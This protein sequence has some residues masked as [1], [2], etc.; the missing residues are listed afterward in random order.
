ME[1]VNKMPTC[2]GCHA[3]F[4]HVPDYNEHWKLMIPEAYKTILEYV[5]LRQWRM[6]IHNSQF[7]DAQRKIQTQISK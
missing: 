3:E 7:E 4:G 5:D 1:R 6:Y 2:S